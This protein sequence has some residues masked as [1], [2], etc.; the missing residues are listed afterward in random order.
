MIKLTAVSILLLFFPNYLSAQ[1]LRL[2]QGTRIV[3]SVKI[4]NNLYRLTPGSNDTAAVIVIEGNGITVD[5]NR[6]TLQGNA[7]AANPDKFTGI[8]I[9]VRNSTNVTI[10]NL[11][12]RGYKIAIIARNVDGLT[13]E[14]SDLSY[15]YRPRLHSTQQKE[16]V[17][18]WLSYHQNNKDEWL[19]YGAGVYLA[20]C[21]NAK[22]SACHITGNQNAL[23]MRD[24]NNAQIMNNDFSFNSGLGI[25]LYRCSGNKIS[26][27]RLVF[28]I[29]GYSHGVYQRGQDSAGILVYEQSNNNLFYKNNVTHGGDGFFLWAGQTT[30][31]TG[32]GGC[33]DNFLLSND[34]SY[35]A[36]NG[37]EMTFSRNAVYQNRIF[38]CE[39]GIWGGY[40]YNSRIH[41]NR[42]RGNKVAI[43]IEHG[44][45]NSIAYNLF[46]RDGQAIKLWANSSQPA[47]WGY[48]KNR[49][50]K[51][52]NYIV[53]SNSFNRNPV[54]FNVAATEAM[55]IF[56]NTY[57]GCETVYKL[58]EGAAAPDTAL[59]YELVE[60]LEND[61][62]PGAQDVSGFD[63]FKGSN[64]WAGRKNIRMTE[65]GPYSFNYPVVWNSNPVDSSDWM[66]FDVLGPAKGKWAVSG[67]LGLDSVSAMSGSFP[68]SIRAKRKNSSVDA[69]NVQLTLEY[70]GPAFTDVFGTAVSGKRSPF[71]FTR[72]FQPLNWHVLWFTMDTAYYNPLREQGLFSPT[73]RM[74][75]VKRDTAAELNYA[76]WGGLKAGGQNFSQFITVADARVE[77]GGR[78]EL[79]VTWQG[80]VRVYLDD[81]VVIDGWKLEK[82]GGD[83]AFNRR[84]QLHISDNQN[85]R[86]EHLGFG[87]FS[88]LSVKILPGQ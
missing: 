76:W 14:N 79:S 27:N 86:V 9:E 1:N 70:N 63:P 47:D 30:M 36:T 7:D 60:K 6:A 34:F 35:A 26:Y 3:K 66:E 33:N 77:K 50:T 40:S 59:Y 23:L 53:A 16:D 38:E 49:D 2:K 41:N 80:A 62:I 17:A 58:G 81:K 44:Q 13:I 71:R 87:A 22:I 75:P 68:A 29:R 72:L 56:S 15:N 67:V 42:F 54:V 78:F 5:F 61:S 20:N 64:A 88:A 19:R 55:N 39:N 12:V 11:R 4:R 45:E 51:S 83:S 37:V 82:E 48:A 8:A 84:I 32:E 31:D 69:V 18:D 52:R 46:D 24:C 85:I 28:N 74:A 65:W 10:R 43:A 25:G 73:A 21:N 57:S